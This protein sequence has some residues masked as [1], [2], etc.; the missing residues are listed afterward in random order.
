MSTHALIRVF[1]DGAHMSTFY[2][3]ADGYPE[4][5]EPVLAATMEVLPYVADPGGP[6]YMAFIELFVS[7]CNA[8]YGANYCVLNA[9]DIY[10]RPLNEPP[11]DYSYVYDVDVT[12]GAAYRSNGLRKPI[13]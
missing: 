7:E 1:Q 3:H 13:S 9:N 2:K 10:G 4:F 5:M 8:R 12:A 11:G 6:N